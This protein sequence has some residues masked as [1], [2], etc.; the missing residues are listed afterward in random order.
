MVTDLNLFFYPEVLGDHPQKIEMSSLWIWKNLLNSNQ[1]F[2]ALG[3]CS[4]VISILEIEKLLLGSSSLSLASVPH[5]KVLFSFHF[6]SLKTNS[7][8]LFLASNLV[9]MDCVKP[10]EW[11]IGVEGPGF[12]GMELEWWC[13]CLC[14]HMCMCVYVSICVYMCVCMFILCEHVYVTQREHCPC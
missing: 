13:V 9:Y 7:Y 10:E 3:G 12:P 1:F 5:F 6:C 4:F 8:I 14:V 11:K 2:E